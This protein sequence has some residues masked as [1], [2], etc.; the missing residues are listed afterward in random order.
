MR[1]RTPKK[2]IG[3]LLV[4]T[5]AYAALLA[6]LTVLNVV[7]ADRFWIGALNLYLPQIAWGVPG[8]LLVLFT[9]RKAIRWIWAPLLCLAW[10][11]GPIMGFCWSA[12]PGAAGATTHLPLRVLSWNVKYGGYN[13]ITQLA[14]AEEIM[15]A[16]PDVVLLQ[17]AQDLLDG[18][19]GRSFKGWKVACRG[20]Y[21]VAS[22]FPIDGVEERPIP[23][24]GEDAACLR[25]RLH[26]GKE[27]LV[28]Y[29]VHFQSPR[30]GLNAFTAVRKR[31]WYL[32]QAINELRETVDARLSQ[33]AV[34]RALVRREVEPVLVGGDL[35]SPDASLACAILREAGLRDA[36]SE[37][38]RGY[39]YTY[40]HL[41]LQHR[42]AWFNASWMRIDHIMLSS[43]L[44]SIAC[45]A[46]EKSVSQHRSVIADILLEKRPQKIPRD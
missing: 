22:R 37:S 10:V 29:N 30:F 38:G 43:R 14:I 16:R 25:C 21:I 7:G 5:C 6:I 39:G 33:A 3:W 24:P 18:P 32:P 41:L 2:S 45:E 20:Q 44:R 42:I 19:I 12:Q 9:A 46:G 23:F 36:F 34:L 15:E 35:N 40:G 17:D 11:A 13:K 27:T 4:F 1:N 8:V 28:I 26:I 31:P